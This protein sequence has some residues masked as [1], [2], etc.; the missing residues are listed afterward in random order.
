[1]RKTYILLI[2]LYITGC[3]NSNEEGQL[4]FVSGSSEKGFNYPY[5]LFLPD[6]IS[7]DSKSVLIVEPNNSGFASDAFNEH[8]EKAERIASLEYYGGNYIARTLNYP[9]LVPVFPRPKE[10][11]KIYTHALDRDVMLQKDNPLERI[12]LQLLSMI[13]HAQDTLRKLGY[14]VHSRI[15][16]TGFSA[17]GTFTNRF[18][19]L[20]PAKVMA[21]AAGG[22]NG[23]LMLPVSELSGKYLDYPLGTNDVEFLLGSEFDSVAFRQ[24]PQFLFMGELDDNDAIP[25]EDGY[26]IGERNLVFELL[27]EE[28]QP[29]RWENCKEIYLKKGVDAQIKTYHETGHEQ[30]EEIKNDIVHFFRSVYPQ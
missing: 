12:D 29:K 26:S 6:S 14:P 21:S 30:P 10:E 24:T 17:S 9:L 23:L 13:E 15:F 25:Y 1:M 20:H 4:L 18:T 3:N 19:L 22:L 28:M 11:W 5:Y 8:I 27:G 2:L 7:T 16:M